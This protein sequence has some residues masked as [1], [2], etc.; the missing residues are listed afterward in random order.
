MSDNKYT[1]EYM[2]SRLR[3]QTRYNEV[4]MV[5]NTEWGWRVTWFFKGEEA[6]TVDAPN[7]REALESAYYGVFES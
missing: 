3:G 1:I 4:L 7:L 6:G 2:E 5:G